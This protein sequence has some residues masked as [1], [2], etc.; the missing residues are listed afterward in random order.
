MNG[1]FRAVPGRPPEGQVHLGKL[2]Q[3]YGEFIG[4]DA[5]R[6]HMMEG[7]QR[8]VTPVFGPDAF[9]DDIA[10]GPHRNQF[11]A[12]AGPSLEDLHRAGLYHEGEF[13]VVPFRT[14]SCAARICHRPGDLSERL[15]CSRR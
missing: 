13:G 15:P 8:G 6:P 12:A 1:F 3:E 7:D 11:L 5:Q 10:R 14:D 4:L 2:A 9:P